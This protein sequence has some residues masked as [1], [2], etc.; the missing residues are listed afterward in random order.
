MVVFN[1]GVYTKVSE[2]SYSGVQ[3]Q[4]ILYHLVVWQ[5]ANRNNNNEFIFNYK[6]IQDIE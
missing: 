2:L 1:F 4:L 5:K 3:W 6:K